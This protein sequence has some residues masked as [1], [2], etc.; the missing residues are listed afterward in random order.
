MFGELLHQWKERAQRA[1]HGGTPRVLCADDDE[2][3]RAL[4]VATLERAGYVV[5]T[6]ANGREALGLIDKRRYSAVLLDLAMPYLHGTT[7]LS[8]IRSS[9]PEMVSRVVVMTGVSDAGL[10]GTEDAGKLLRK[11][12]G[13]ERLLE[14]VADCATMDETVKMKASPRA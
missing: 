13:R 9:K 8:L 10:L 6:A 5:D 3:I 11:P 14:A 4:C 1:I 12:F 2:S 7:L